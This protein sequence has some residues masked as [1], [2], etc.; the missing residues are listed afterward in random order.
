LR[1]LV[2]SD[3]HGNADALRRVLE[4]SGRW[5]HLWIL[6]D[7]VDYGPEP[8]VVI[9]VVR[10]LKPDVIVQGNHDHAVANGADCRCDP[11]VHE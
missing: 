8:H 7:L 2:I 5:D 3:I 11:V 4:D 9:D 10:E 1:I 6:G